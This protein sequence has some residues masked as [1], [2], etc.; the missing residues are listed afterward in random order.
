M[1]RSLTDYPLAGKRVLVRVD[2]NV[3]LEDGRVVDDTRIRAA[4]PTIR[5]LLDQGCPVVLMLPPRPAQGAGRRRAAH[6]ARGGAPRGAARPPRRDRGRLR[7]R[8]GRAG[9][10]RAQARRRAAAREPALPRGGDRQRRRL[11]QAARR[12]SATSTSTTPSARLTAR[13]PPRR[14]SRTTCPRVAGLLMTTRAR[15]PRPP[16]ARPG[17][18]VRR[19][20]R[21][22]QG[23]GQDQP[24]P[25]HARPSPTRCSSAAPWPTPSSPPRAT[26][27]ARPRAPATRSPSP[28]EILA[29]AGDARGRARAARPTSWWRARRSPARRR[30]SCAADGIA[31]DE[32]ALDIGP[33]TTAE[34]V[35]QLARRRHDLL[36]RPDGPVRDRRSSR[37]A[38]SAIGEAIAGGVAVTV[39]GGGDTVSAVAHA[40][41]WRAA[42]PTCPRAAAPPWSSW[43]AGRCPAWRR[44]WIASD[45]RDDGGHGGRSWRATGRC[46]RRRRRR[47]DVLRRPSVPLVRRRRRPRRAHLPAVRRP[48]AGA[49]RAPSTRDDQA[50]APRPCTTRPRAPSPA[51]SRRGMLVELGVPYVI[52]GPLRAPAVLQRE[53]RRPGAQGPRGA[54]RRPAARSCAA[55]RRSRSARPARPRARSAASSTP[56]SP[57]SAPAELADVAIAYEP[58][59]A[60][61]TGVT[62]TPEQAQ[63]TVAFCRAHACASASAT[64]PTACAS[65]TAAASRPTTSTCSWRSRTSTACSSAAPASTRRSSPHRRA[66]WS[67]RDADPGDAGAGDAVPPGRPRRAGRLGRRPAGSGQRHEPGRHAGLR[68]AAGRVPARRPRRVRP[69]GGTAAGPDGQLRGRPPQHRRRPRRLPGPHAH[70]PARSRTAASSRT[71]CSRQAC[72]KAARAGQPRSTSWASSPTAA[73]T[74]D[75]GHLDALPRA[76]RAREASATSSCTRSSTAATRR[77]RAPRATSPTV[78]AAHGRA[79]RRPLSASISGRYYAMDR[80]TRWDRVKLAY[81]ALVY[82]EGFFAADAAGG[83]RRRLRPRRERRVRAPDDR[84]ARA[85]R[86]RAATATSASSST[87]ARTAPASSRAPSPSAG[88]AEFDRGPHP[89]SVDFV[90]MTQY[91]KEFPLPVAFPPDHPR[92]VLADVLAEHGLRQLHIAETEKY[93]HVTFF[94]NGGVEKEVE[95]EER[96]LVPSPRDVP[97]YDHKPEMS[98]LGVTDELVAAHRGGHVRLHRRELRQRRHGR[99]HRRHPGRRQGRGDG[100]RVPRPGR[101]RRDAL[102]AAPASSPPTTATPTTCW[103]R[104]AAPTRR[105]AP[106]WCPFVATVPAMRVREGGRLCDL[107]PTVL[108]LL[109]VEQP[110]EMTGRDLLEPVA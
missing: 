110:P 77:R 97:T 55:A 45:G 27:S 57:R 7:R 42:S 67:L 23:L 31:A 26:R 28:R 37:P 61:G 74:A 47:K 64:P 8:R 83:G 41:A 15:G 35:H 104:T 43:R 60:I 4:L 62:A 80:D 103:S 99:P 107:A 91:K 20:A 52:L 18:A 25:A 30:A 1:K 95:G 108:A 81:D 85:R 14:A 75:L 44:S 96:V 34:F 102:A 65:C 39:A 63:E 68:P 87:S 109:G 58:I 105:T 38:R 56:T 40:S 3:P 36:E 98:A 70:Q 88:F 72:A 59:W 5:Y 71:R 79:R 93:A 12:R 21:R 50:S 51:R 66:S 101:R 78:Q 22:P 16:A 84:R 11:R 19:G 100:R 46:T 53:R 89:P 17:A 86:A 48:A 29:E 24:H 69:G 106:T 73:C 2:F 10:G 90:T 76:G 9:G 33:Q 54:R 13:T 49:R 6:G 32:M 94:F 92:H 82:G